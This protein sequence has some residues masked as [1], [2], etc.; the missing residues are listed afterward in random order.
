MKKSITNNSKIKYT[1]L[2][3]IFSILFIFTALFISKPITAYADGSSILQS[4]SNG[5]AVNGQEIDSTSTANYLF[6]A[7][8]SERTGILFYIIDNTGGL[9]GSKKIL[10]MDDLI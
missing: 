1:L 8:S 9:Y 5:K 3:I 4:T 6:W 10:I 2:S 7:A